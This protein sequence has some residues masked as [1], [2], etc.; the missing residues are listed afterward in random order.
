MAEI[1]EMV[2][3]PDGRMTGGVT[4]GDGPMRDLT[5]VS[6]AIIL[7]VLSGIQLTQNEAVSVV[8]QTLH[9]YD[10]DFFTKNKDGN[11][12]FDDRAPRKEVK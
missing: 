2:V 7:P 8:T 12:I 3:H 4:L 10:F 6:V 1:L 9:Y 11:V 5:A